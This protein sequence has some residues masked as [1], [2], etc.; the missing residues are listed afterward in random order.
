MHNANM[1]HIRMATVIKRE[2]IFKIQMFYF[3]RVHN[4]NK[5]PFSSGGTVRE[6]VFFFFNMFI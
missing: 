6:P 2:L 5:I 4:T 1:D 3:V